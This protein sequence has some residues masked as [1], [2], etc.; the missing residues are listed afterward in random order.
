VFC[1]LWG[2]FL[3][4]CIIWSSFSIF[5]MNRITQSPKKG[6]CAINIQIAFA[7]CNFCNLKCKAKL[8]AKKWSIYLHLIV[9]MDAERKAELVNVNTNLD[10]RI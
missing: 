10:G 1:V 6:Y 7:N 9:S 8:W 3:C 5:R 4:N 2:R